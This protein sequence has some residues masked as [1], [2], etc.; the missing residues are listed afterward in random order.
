MTPRR[1]SGRKSVPG[2]PATP[3]TPRQVRRRPR[4]ADRAG[5]P[6]ARWDERPGPARYRRPALRYRSSVL[7]L[8]YLYVLHYDPIC[9][10]NLTSRTAPAGSVRL[11][12]ALT[13]TPTPYEVSRR[14]S[15]R[16]PGLLSNT[17]CIP[18]GGPTARTAYGLAVGLLSTRIAPPPCRM[19]T[20]GPIRT[21]STAI[22]SAPLA[23][24]ELT[25]N[26]R[27]RSRMICWL[28]PTRCLETSDR[29]GLTAGR[30]PA[31]SWPCG[32]CETSS[33]CAES[34]LRC[35]VTSRVVASS[36]RT[37]AASTRC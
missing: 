17:S 14:R 35:L 8:R 23:H 24:N 18:C 31:A 37:R 3:R 36:E 26:C 28:P 7:S 13:F 30:G 21:P 5:W 34:V 10:A 29:F 9:L 2:M 15:R 16:R 22:A 27:S 20:F 33:R 6:P 25:T 4:S 11:S 1:L 12:L 19:V 32:A